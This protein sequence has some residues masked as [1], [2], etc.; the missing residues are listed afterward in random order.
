MEHFLIPFPSKKVHE[1]EE[2]NFQTSLPICPKNDNCFEYLRSFFPRYILFCDYLR[3]VF[4]KKFLQEK[5][6][7]SELF[8]CKIKYDKTTF[9]DDI[10]NN[11][12]I[13]ER[14]TFFYSL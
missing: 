14:N 2:N 9:F 7:S 3:E 10:V 11:F 12:S 8:F 6:I 5:K 1:L 13:P 4:V